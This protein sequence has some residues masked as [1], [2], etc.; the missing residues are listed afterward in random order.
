MRL[1][2][3]ECWQETIL[4]QSAGDC[5]ARFRDRVALIEATE[6]EENFTLR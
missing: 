2:R 6:H 4:D 3:K 1:P 5:L